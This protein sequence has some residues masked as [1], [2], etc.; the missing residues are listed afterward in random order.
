M[1]KSSLVGAVVGTALA[2]LCVGALSG[3]ADAD[4]GRQSPIPSCGETVPREPFDANCLS[5]EPDGADENLA[6][7]EKPVPRSAFR[8]THSYGAS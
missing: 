5:V 2:A 6:P 3:I 1:G 8:G 7:D 4:A